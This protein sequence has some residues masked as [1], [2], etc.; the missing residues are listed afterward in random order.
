MP[1]LILDWA[2]GTYMLTAAQRN[3]VISLKTQLD[4]YNNDMSC[5]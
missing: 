2:T 4:K 5:P 3:L 1:L